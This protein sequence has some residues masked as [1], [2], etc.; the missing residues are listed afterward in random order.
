MFF[1]SS[2]L[3]IRRMSRP[4]GCV[5]GLKMICIS[6]LF[7]L[8]FL[9][10][11]GILKLCKDKSVF[12]QLQP[13]IRLVYGVSGTLGFAKKIVVTVWNRK[14]CLGVANTVGAFRLY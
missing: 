13:V 4:C 12:F 10:E 1:G 8:G 3:L 7:E 14:V 2:E 5:E 6:V 11:N 9:Y